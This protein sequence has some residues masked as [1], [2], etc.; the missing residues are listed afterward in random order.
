MYLFL[1]SHIFIYLYF[2]FIHSKCVTKTIF[3]ISQ[4]K[5]QFFKHKLYTANFIKYSLKLANVSLIRSLVSNIL[6]IVLLLGGI[7]RC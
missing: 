1:F 3:S 7:K 5:P 2:Y 6:N 4:N